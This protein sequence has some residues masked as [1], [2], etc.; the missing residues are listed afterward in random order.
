VFAE[1]IAELKRRAAGRRVTVVLS[2]HYVRYTLLPASKKLR[3]EA[4]RQ[5]YARHMFEVTYGMAT[6]KWEIQLSGR[7]AA[8]IDAELL[9][10]LRT[11]PTLS[12]VQPYLMAAFNA[13][14][15]RFRGTSAWFIAQEPG[16]LALA[17]FCEGDW[18]LIRT[19]RIE[20]GWAQTL[21]D[22]LERESAAAQV[23]HCPVAILCSEDE[24]PERAGRYE[25]IEPALGPRA[26]AMV[27]H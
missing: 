17:L 16:R 5:A 9:E 19:R 23:P 27:L 6:R 22:L 2:N 25:I 26:H 11:I 14:R 3:S 24:P 4:D 20:A 21:E 7:V 18:K 13:R 10:E 1:P 8:A 12:S 15:R